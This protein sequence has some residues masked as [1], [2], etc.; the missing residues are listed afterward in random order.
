MSPI[1]T[2]TFYKVDWDGGVWISSG[3]TDAPR[4]TARR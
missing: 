3:A 4:V 2:V 1:L